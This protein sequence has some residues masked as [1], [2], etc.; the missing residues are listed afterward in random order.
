[1]INQKN[2]IYNS[3]NTIS[4]DINLG[5]CSLCTRSLTFK[6]TWVS[7]GRQ[8]MQ[9]DP[10]GESACTTPPS[11]WFALV[12]LDSSSSR[13][14]PWPAMRTHGN[15]VP[16][17]SYSAEGIVSYLVIFSVFPDHMLNEFN[18]VSGARC[19]ILPRQTGL[20]FHFCKKRRKYILSA[21]KRL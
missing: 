1:M 14:A 19:V 6:T 10:R 4:S 20:F 5:P 8:Q 3:V 2:H 21:I 18:D 12:F 13:P 17:S 16:P 7:A 15:D 11:S 9:H